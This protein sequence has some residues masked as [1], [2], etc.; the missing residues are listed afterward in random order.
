MEP[1]VAQ[2]IS[3][4]EAEVPH[5]GPAQCDGL[6]GCGRYRNLNQLGDRVRISAEPFQIVTLLDNDRGLAIFAKEQGRI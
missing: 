3:G 5:L 1:V 2:G 6:A 4:R